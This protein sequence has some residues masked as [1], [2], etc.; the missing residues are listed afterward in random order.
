MKRSLSFL[1][2]AILLQLGGLRGLAA[3]PDAATTAQENEPAC[4]AETLAKW[5]RD[6]KEGQPAPRRG[7]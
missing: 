6:A 5:I 2:A 4:Q 1:L 7:P 3:E